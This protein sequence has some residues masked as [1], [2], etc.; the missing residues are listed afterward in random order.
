MVA[1]VI[2]VIGEALGTILTG[3]GTDPN[4]GPL[5]AL[6]ALACWPL[7]PAA[8]PQP[9]ILP[10]GQHTKGHRHKHPRLHPGHLRR[11]HAAGRRDQRRPV[12]GGP[13]LEPGLVPGM[14]DGA[15]SHLLMGI[16]MADSLVASLT[17]LSNGAWIVVFAVMTAWFGWCLR[18]DSRGQGACAAYRG[19]HAPHLCTVPP[20]STCSPR[21]PGRPWAADSGMACMGGGAADGMQTLHAPTLAFVFVLLLIGYTVR[22]LDRQACADGY[23]HVVAGTS[24]PRPR[25]PPPAR[26]WRAAGRRRRRGR[27][28]AAGRPGR[29]GRPEPP[30]PSPPRNGCCSRPPR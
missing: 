19:H 27:D 6:L 22:D 15:I 28:H 25:W 8:A 20:C 23:F 9:Q 1:A 17:T 14:L 3:G 13:G 18:Q 24:R 10:T 5:L 12:G 30:R 29:S 11:G 4:S 21:S 26:P 2:W 16:A 7:V